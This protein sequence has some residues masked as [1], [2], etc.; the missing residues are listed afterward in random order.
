M[1]PVQARLVLRPPAPTLILQLHECT[2]CKHRF[3][4]SSQLDAG[5]AVN[6]PEDCPR[7]D[8]PCAGQKFRKVDD[9]PL[10]Y[11]GRR[12]RGEDEPLV[13]TGRRG[14]GEGEPLV[15]T[16]R[17]C[18]GEDEPLVYMGRR[19]RGED[20]PL[21]YTGRRGKGDG[22][23]LVYTDRRG[24]GE[25]EPLVYTGRRGR[26][27]GEGRGGRTSPWCTAYRSGGKGGG[28]WTMM[29]TGKQGEGR[30]GWAR[31]RPWCARV[32]TVLVCLRLSACLSVR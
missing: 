15:Y 22:K 10:V 20:E 17:R 3:M 27:E 11:T 26:G 14:R 21:V 13:Y 16:G 4:L 8:K 2:R 9:E 23:P 18:R 6:L 5:G 29:C 24:R 12:G 25:G 19:G 31:M 7:T 28:R 1:H 30:R 32:D